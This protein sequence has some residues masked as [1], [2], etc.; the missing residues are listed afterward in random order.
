MSCIR[1][2][3]PLYFRHSCTKMRAVIKVIA[4]LC[5]GFLIA[6][7][8]YAHSTLLEQPAAYQQCAACHGPAAQG[9]AQL[10]APALA[11]LSERYLSRQLINFKTGMRGS[12]E[13]DTLGQQMQAMMKPLSIDKDIPELAAYLA[14]LVPAQQGAQLKGDLT[15]GTRYYQGKCGACHGGTA[16]GNEA[17]NAPRL[18][19]QSNDYLKRQMRNFATGLRGTHADDKYGRQMAMMAKTTSGKE[20]DD[21]LYYISLQ[22]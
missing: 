17:L 9:N 4:S 7:A 14:K 6:P 16:Q 13:Q 2:I 8:T 19:G 11:G 21:I 22:E 15:N 1:F 10:N 12:H 18:A 20:L 5:C 3:S